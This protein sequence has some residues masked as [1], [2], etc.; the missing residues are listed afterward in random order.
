[1][2]GASGFEP[3]ASWSRTMNRRIICNLAVGTVV[4]HRCALL[5]V[6]KHFACQFAMA[7][8]TARNTSTQGVGT[9]LGTVLSDGLKAM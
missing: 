5:L 2:V 9:K 1:M 8:A 7:L 4:I 3:P 6:I